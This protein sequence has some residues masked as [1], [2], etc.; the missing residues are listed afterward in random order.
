[1]RLFQ[2]YDMLI[3]HYLT[4]SVFIIKMCERLVSEKL[5]HG[6]GR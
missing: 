3:D 1:M 2:E 6:I 5:I 4:I